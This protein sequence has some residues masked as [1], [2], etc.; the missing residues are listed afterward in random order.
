MLP[1]LDVPD[2]ETLTVRVCADGHCQDGNLQAALNPDL[3][4]NVP[5][6]LERDSVELQVTVRDKR[7]TLV[8][9]GRGK[10]TVQ[11]TYPNGPDCPP[12]CR[13]VQVRLAGGQLVAA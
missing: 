2:G 13:R 10:A 9:R 3:Q 7:G 8:A 5:V 6:P 11:V 4:A 1:G 12:A